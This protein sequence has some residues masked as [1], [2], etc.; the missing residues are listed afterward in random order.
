MV[1]L[2]RSLWKKTL[3]FGP[4]RPPVNSWIRA[5]KLTRRVVSDGA[6]FGSCGVLWRGI[7]IRLIEVL[8]M[9]LLQ[10]GH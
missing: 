2:I 7:A 9:I 5:S 6:G 3:P 8:G 4:A 10:F 1:F